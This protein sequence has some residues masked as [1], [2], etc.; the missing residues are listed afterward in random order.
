[1]AIKVSCTC[2]Q[3]FKA[4][5]DLAGKRV[6]C[7]KCSQPLVIPLPE[8]PDEF[9]LEDAIE[10]PRYNPL[11]DLLAEEG[12]KQA[13]AGPVCPS[14]SEPISPQAVICV[15]CGFNL[16][17]GEKLHSSFDDEDD[18]A[19][20]MAGMSETEKMLYK[21]ERELQDMPISAEG[22]K[23]GDEGDS[24]IVA[25]GAIVITAAVVAL[26]VF[27][28]IQLDKIEDFNTPLVSAWMSVLFAVGAIVSVTITAFKERPLE[29]YLCLTV[30]YTLWYAMT[31]GLYV[32]LGLI[33][34]FSSIAAGC[35]SYLNAS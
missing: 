6:R 35:F 28:I 16:Q 8:E 22:E 14:C 30:V 26:S 34:L 9:K 15:Q 32:P 11:D 33:V 27:V 17:T 25:I 5:D 21:A 29:G 23:F 3:S 31:R 20:A 13:F 19:A 18:D 1:M 7:P 24:Y 10:V 4:K 12:V 2:G